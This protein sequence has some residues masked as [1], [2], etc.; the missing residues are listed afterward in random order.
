[1][2]SRKLLSIALPLL[3][4]ASIAIPGSAPVAAQTAIGYQKPPAPIEALL[5]APATPSV[6]VSPDGRT[7]LIAQPQT[8]PS[9]AEV[10]QPRYRLAGLRFNPK[11]SGPSVTA[12][13]IGLR[14][15]AAAPGSPKA[16]A[17]LPVKLRASNAIWSPDSRHIAFVQ[18]S[19][20]ALELWVIDVAA[21]SAHR[22]G[23]V[24]LNAVLGRPCSW[25]PSSNGLICKTVP[26]SRGPAPKVSDVPTG[27][28]ISENL[29]KATPAP[30]YEDMLSTPDDENIFEYYATSELAE[31][32]LTGP[33]HNLPIKGLIDYA[34]PSPDGRYALVEALHR[35]FSYTVPS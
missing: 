18:R 17:G 24:K 25:L 30:T 4:A 10:A 11:T 12:D 3:A 19:D 31:I 26:A 27:P 2:N 33:V 7:L 13:S 9:I 20:A 14:L 28:H 15:Q 16:I 6:S 21:A 23:L 22:L 1:M 34:S 35:P 29:G 8:F 5:D 32:P